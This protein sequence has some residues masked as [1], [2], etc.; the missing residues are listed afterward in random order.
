M[1]SWSLQTHSTL[2][3]ITVKMSKGL[4]PDINKLDSDDQFF[5]DLCNL[6]EEHHDERGIDMET[7][8]YNMNYFTE[9]WLATL[10]LTGYLWD[11]DG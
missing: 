4:P 8:L 11:Y 1:E 3:F 5:Q 10:Y 7:L 9:D 6:M 2:D